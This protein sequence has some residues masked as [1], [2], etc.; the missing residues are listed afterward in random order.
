MDAEEEEGGA[1]ARGDDDDGARRRR[2]FIF[3]SLSLWPGHPP[4]NQKKHYPIAGFSPRSPF[5]FKKERILVRLRAGPPPLGAPWPQARAPLADWRA[6]GAAISSLPPQ[7]AARAPP[8]LAQHTH[9]QTQSINNIF[10]LLSLRRASPIHTRTH[11]RATPKQ[12]QCSPSKPPPLARPCARAPPCASRAA[13][14]P[15]CARSSSSRSWATRPWTRC[16]S[17]GGVLHLLAPS[18]LRRRPPPPPFVALGAPASGVVVRSRF[19]ALPRPKTLQSPSAPPTPASV[20]P[21]APFRGVFAPLITK[22]PPTPE[23]RKK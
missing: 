17:F 18:T 23:K 22:P 1:R 14:S 5:C 3:L 12:T 7:I 11:A 2:P 15:P 4:T 8:S 21:G 19:F 13:S 6:A 20:A 9:K 10:A 16:V